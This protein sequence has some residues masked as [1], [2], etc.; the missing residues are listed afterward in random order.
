M[1]IGNRESIYA[2]AGISLRSFP[3]VC[4]VEDKSVKGFDVIGGKDC[5]VFSTVGIA[6]WTERSGMYR[7]IDG[8]VAVCISPTEKGPMVEFCRSEGGK[9]KVVATVPS[10]QLIGMAPA[11]ERLGS[12]ADVL[13][14]ALQ[15]RTLH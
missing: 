5:F 3:A 9:L 7:T 12:Y 4:V 1:Q 15:A 13:F 6:Y 10:V 8:A 11:G 14:Q 2:E